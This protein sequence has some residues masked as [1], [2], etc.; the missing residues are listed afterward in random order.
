MK[1]QQIYAGQ[2]ILFAASVLI[3][4]ETKASARRAEA[5]VLWLC[6]GELGLT[7]FDGGLE[8]LAHFGDHRVGEARGGRFA[9]EVSGTNPLIDASEH[10]G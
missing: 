5:L 9:A 8:L 3:G 10:R 1:G 7:R 2:Y 4:K 6:G